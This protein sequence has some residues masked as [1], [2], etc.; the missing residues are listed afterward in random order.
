M[1]IQIKKRRS[2]RPTLTCIRSDGSRTWSDVQPFSPYHDI[3][4]LAVERVLD[5]RE[6]FFGLVA[7]DWDLDRFARPGTSKQLSA[8]AAL[9]EH[10]VG[11]LDRERG[12]GVCWSAAEFTDA[13][14]A[15]LGPGIPAVTAEQLAR[16]RV[17]RDRM[18]A[19]WE[20]LSAGETL[21]LEYSAGAAT[22]PALAADEA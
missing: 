22:L 18:I 12:A 13:L 10:L 11:L 9:A 5:L 8:D 1:I 20:G 2:G 15:A 19:A 3:T 14:R 16:I 4:H 6:A 7:A 21:E 17:D